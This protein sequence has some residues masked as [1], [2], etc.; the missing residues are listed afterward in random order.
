MMMKKTNPFAIYTTLFLLAVWY[1]TTRLGLINPV[2]LP[3]PGAVFRRFLTMLHSEYAGSTLFGHIV[4]S[5][6][7][8][9]ISFL[10][11]AAIGVPLGV[12]MEH[13]RIVRGM[14]DPV[15]EFYRPLPPLAY[16]PLI[17]VWFGIGFLAKSVLIGVAAL[18]PIIISTRAGVASVPN[19][20]KHAAL[21]MGARKVQVLLHVV[22]P[23]AL[24]EIIS[25]L[26]IGL[27][28][29]WST[30]V[31]G[32]MV[33][34]TSGLGHMV[35]TASNYLETD[36]VVLGIIIIGIIAVAFELAIRAAQ[37]KFVPWKGKA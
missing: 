23:A 5:V 31:A 25:G 35:L 30:L 7:L 26:R 4:S 12:A 21:S 19:E 33:A 17:I 8:V 18:A 1:L 28:V 34:A 27:G 14:A 37:R 20:M 9:T 36:A 13:S 6:R 32:E 16:L 15:V 10:G 11:A 24:P 29:A 22:L 2:L 3:P